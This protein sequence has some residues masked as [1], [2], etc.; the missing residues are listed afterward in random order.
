MRRLYPLDCTPWVEL[1]S[2]GF[3]AAW[4]GGPSLPTLKHSPVLDRIVAGKKKNYRSLNFL[5]WD[6]HQCILC[7]RCGISESRHTQN[8]SDSRQE[9]TGTVSSHSAQVLYQ[10]TNVSLVEYLDIRISDRFL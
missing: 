7:N 6:R 5:C 9:I 3:L 1:R 4:L 2:D 10:R 8:R